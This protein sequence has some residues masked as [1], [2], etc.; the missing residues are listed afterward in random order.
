[1]KKLILPIALLLCL[2]NTL[3]SAKENPSS[4][5]VKTEI[6]DIINV[7]EPVLNQAFTKKNPKITQVK[8]H[9]ITPMVS[10]SNSSTSDFV[11]QVSPD[12]LCEYV[13]GETLNTPLALRYQYRMKKGNRFGIDYMN[14]YSSLLL[15]PKVKDNQLG[16]YGPTVPAFSSNL[17]GFNVHYSKAIDIKLLEVFGFIGAG[18]YLGNSTNPLT[19][20]YSWYKNASAEFYDFAPAVT[21]NVIKP[22][23]PMLNFGAGVRLKHLEGGINNQFSLSSPVKAIQ[24]QGNTFQNN[25]RLKSIGYYIAYRWEF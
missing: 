11:L 9:S 5:L 13:S 25:I 21:H 8:R 6:S 20:D 1:M 12:L 3:V 24:Y 23:I 15:R 10:L 7:H 18:G 4:K 2:S 14:M 22:F 17:H 19:A 16:F